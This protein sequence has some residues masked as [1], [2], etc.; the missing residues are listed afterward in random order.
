MEIVLETAC[1]LWH[2][3]L[4]VSQ[5]AANSGASFMYLATSFL[6][7]ETSLFI[8]G[9]PCKI[10]SG[11]ARHSMSLLRRTTLSSGNK[12][13]SNHVSRALEGVQRMVGG[14]VE[15]SPS[16]WSIAALRRS[17]VSEAGGHGSSQGKVS[18]SGNGSSM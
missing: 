4:T 16:Q 17:V 8:L 10:L 9:F 3:P 18:M 6:P 2:C 7:L 5:L 15:T 11:F 14:G 1:P 12:P 13:T